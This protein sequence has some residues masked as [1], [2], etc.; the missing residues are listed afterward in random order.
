MYQEFLKQKDD[1]I[2]N[3]RE[4]LRRERLTSGTALEEQVR[5]I[6]A[7]QDSMWNERLEKKV[8]DTEKAWAARLSSAEVRE[9]PFPP[10]RVPTTAH[11]F[12]WCGRVAGQ[13]SSGAAAG[14][15]EGGRGAPRVARACH[16]QRQRRGA[17]QDRRRAGSGALRWDAA[18][19]R[20]ADH[21]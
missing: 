10:A 16:P 12:L 17:D 7:E 14:P 2:E 19:A 20:V 1:Q 11:P 3:L 8:S 18:L 13:A 4:T 6:E 21:H 9:R 15:R 5:K